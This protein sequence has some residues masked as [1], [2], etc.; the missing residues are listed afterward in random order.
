MVP[1]D[2]TRGHKL[3]Y[4]KF[5]IQIRK[6]VFIVRVDKAGCG[7]PI[8]GDT[9]NSPGDAPGQPAIADTALSRGLEHQGLSAS[10]F[11]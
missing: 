11:I 2:S 4:K 8:F 7:V 9:Q 10:D 1:S 6:N 5:Y 3:K